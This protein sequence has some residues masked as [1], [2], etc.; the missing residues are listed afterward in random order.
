M[1]STQLFS[2]SHS[3]IRQRQFI[4]CAF[5]ACVCSCDSL[6]QFAVPSA[7]LVCVCLCE[8]KRFWLRN[9]TRTHIF[10]WAMH[11]GRSH[12]LCQCVPV[13]A[14]V[15]TW[16]DIARCV[17]RMI[18]GKAIVDIRNTWLQIW[19][20]FYGSMTTGIIWIVISV[21]AWLCVNP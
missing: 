1:A 20:Y 5:Y 19:G 14:V 18:A 15:W 9:H 11:S 16:F 10:A 21:R 7:M 3:Y 6:I 13:C 17:Q 12:C 2:I 4:Q 8:R